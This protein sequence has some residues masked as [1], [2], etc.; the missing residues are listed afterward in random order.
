MIVI[1]SKPNMKDA[2]LMSYNKSDK[3]IKLK[4]ILTLKWS[5]C[6]ILKHRLLF[7]YPQLWLFNFVA[8]C[9]DPSDPTGFRAPI[10]KYTWGM[11]QI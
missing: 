5:Y 9:H 1:P 7:G 11:S 8:G 4:Y 3:N 6:I 2:C 10:L